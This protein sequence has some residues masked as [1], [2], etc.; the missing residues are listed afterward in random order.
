MHRGDTQGDPK[1]QAM[2]NV[3]REHCSSTE[4]EHATNQVE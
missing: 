3:Q 4:G 2:R 1:A